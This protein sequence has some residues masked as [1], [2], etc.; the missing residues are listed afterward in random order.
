MIDHCKFGEGPSSQDPGIVHMCFQAQ[1]SSAAKKRGFCWEPKPYDWFSGEGEVV[2]CT[3]AASI[4]SVADIST[5]KAWVIIS[6]FDMFLINNTL[7]IL[8]KH[9]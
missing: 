4:H 6:V 3:Q 1:S 5:Q 8:P 2:I 7:H 9:L